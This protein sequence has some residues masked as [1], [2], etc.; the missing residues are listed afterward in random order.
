MG[1]ITEQTPQ[2]IRCTGGKG[3][4]EKMLYI[5]CHQANSY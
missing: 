3:A 1:K 2:Q 5:N 4:Y